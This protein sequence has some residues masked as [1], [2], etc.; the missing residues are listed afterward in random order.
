LVPYLNKIGYVETKVIIKD[1]LF[2]NYKILNTRGYVRM[3]IK[4]D[5]EYT[6]E[7]C[8]ELT[9]D[10]INQEVLWNGNKFVSNEPVVLCIKIYRAKLY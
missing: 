7:N 6:I 1:G 4:D 9:G 3:G 10:S 8:N 2:V 5:D